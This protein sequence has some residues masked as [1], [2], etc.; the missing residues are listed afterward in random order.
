MPNTCWSVQPR[1][2]ATRAAGS[3]PSLEPPTWSRLSEERSASSHSTASSHSSATGGTT[4]VA[5]TCSRSISAKASSGLGVGESTTVPP[6]ISV[7]SRPGQARAK[8]CAVGSTT[9]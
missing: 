9:R 1:A 6:A 4:A 2:G 8:L 7:P 3:V 5:V